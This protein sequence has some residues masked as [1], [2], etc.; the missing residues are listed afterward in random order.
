MKKLIILFMALVVA[1]LIVATGCTRQEQSNNAANSPP[2]T[3]LILTLDE[4]AAYNGKNGKPAYVAVDGV[5]YDVTERPAW[6]NGEHNGY[7]AGQDLTD[8]IKNKSPHGISKLSGVP[9]VGS[10][11]K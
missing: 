9:V 7:Q 5:I 3:K 1:L 11:A 4:L 2:E 10:V 8:I 6:K